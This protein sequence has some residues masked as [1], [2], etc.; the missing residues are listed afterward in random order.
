M[1]KTN[2]KKTAALLLA[3]GLTAA[4]CSSG[5]DDLVDG[6]TDA[7][8][9]VAGD[10]EDVL[11]GDDDAMEDEYEAM[12]DEA[13]EADDADEAAHADD[14]G[15]GLDIEPA[16]DIP[17]TV[18]EIALASEDFSTLVTAL[19]EADLVETLQGDG[20]FT[21]FAPTN[22]AFDA[23]LT[24]ADVTIEE[25]LATSDL[26]DTLTYHVVAGNVFAEDAIAADGTA[27]ETLSG[28]SIDIS[29]V[30]GFVVLNDSA[31]VITADLA[32]GNGVVHIIDTVLTPLTAGASDS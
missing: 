20:P 12:E 26:A 22:D 16:S 28:D 31:T 3:F 7:A 8:G 19:T 18:V 11:I 25:L 15:T 17:A 6:A 9:D 32:A 21:V 2:T 13:E 1:M 23:V 5:A 10:V 14:D 24:G 29:V 27:V 4:A 30:N